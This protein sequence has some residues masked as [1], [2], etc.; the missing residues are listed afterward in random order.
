MTVAR[1]PG[2]S[3]RIR[4]PSVSELSTAFPSK[5]T[6]TSPERMPAF[7]A[8]PFGATSTTNAPLPTER[9]SCWRTRGVTDV[10][11]TPRNA[12][13]AD[14]FLTACVM[15]SLAASIA[16]A[17]PMFSACCAPA[18]LIPITWPS[19]FTSGPPEFPGLMAASVWITWVYVREPPEKF[20]SAT[21]TSR[22]SEETMPLVTVGPPFRARA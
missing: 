17:K 6:I 1:S 9:F 18:V 8:G 4:V 15:V 7:W 16:M 10:V 13:G 3:A 2:W 21:F 14:G 5:R 19:R 12:T 20:G 11:V 22:F